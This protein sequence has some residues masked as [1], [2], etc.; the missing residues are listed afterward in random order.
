[1][2]INISIS[3][4]E[5]TKLGFAKVTLD[6]Q[7][8]NASTILDLEFS[9][10]YYRCGIPSGITLDF[11][12]LSSLIYVTDKLIPRKKASDNWTRDLSLKIPVSDPGHWYPVKKDIEICLSFL[13]GDRWQL[14]FS[15]LTHSLVRPRVHKRKS[16]SIN[17][18]P[19]NADAVCLF[20]GGLDSLIGAIDWLESNPQGNLLLVGHHDSAVKGPLSDQN[21][22]VQ[23]LKPHYPN[24]VDSLHIRAGQKP[25]GK[26]I[27]FRSR[28][29]LFLAL[30][31]YVSQAIS[32]RAPLLIP[33]NGGIS[34]NIPLTPSRRGSCSTRTVHPFFLSILRQS[35][36]R[37]GIRN[38]II[39]PL[40]FK[41]KGECVEQCLNQEVLHM[42]ALESVSCAKRGHTRT[43]VNKTAKGCG[44]C[45]PCI[46]RRSALHKIGFDIESYGRDICQGELDLDS[47]NDS[48][49]DFR[50][51]ISFLS[52]NPTHKE[53]CHMLLANGELP[54]TLLPR[55]A[56]LVVRQMDEMRTLLCDKAREE[57]KQRA[58]I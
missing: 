27:S 40:E 39:N 30:G 15:N 49:N 51:C 35:L 42:T 34:I 24:R 36:D 4:T 18:D 13:T 28:S 11:L 53:I 38:S 5:S 14:E 22:L 47:F 55:Y 50:A 3:P 45:I 12:F 58:G 41:T 57:I 6:C 21:T 31:I 1:M 23:I 33:E 10:L 54:L 52:R 9:P 43:W 17:N 48:A 32:H 56:D 7:D 16:Q 26:E 25:T 37:L 20:S 44:R 19:L 46:Y 2:F 8:I 29:L